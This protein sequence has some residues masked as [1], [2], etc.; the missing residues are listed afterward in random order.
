MFEKPF[1]GMF[2]MPNLT[3]LYE[4]NGFKVSKLVVMG[5]HFFVVQH[6]ATGRRYIRRTLPAVDAIIRQMV[7]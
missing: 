5:T 6:T 7:L 3:F 1:P 4:E 2:H